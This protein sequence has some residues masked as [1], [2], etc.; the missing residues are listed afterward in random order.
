LDFLNNNKNY[1][2]YYK[3]NYLS[4]D[5][6]SG[7][8]F[9]LAKNL[10][11]DLNGFNDNLFWMEDMDFC[12][13]A[14]TLGHKIAYLP[15]TKLI[16]YIG[17]SS[18]KNWVVTISN[19]LLSKIKYFKLHHGSSEVMTLITAIYLLVV[20]KCAYLL[21]LS[22]FSSVYRKKFIGYLTTLKLLLNKQY[23]IGL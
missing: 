9:F 11:N 2:H 10:F 22:P 15:N 14:S 4:V 1:T 8:A 3:S 12:K 7:G 5:A 17:K 16:H 6:I 21:F 18:E 20:V 23:Q 19:R 13:R